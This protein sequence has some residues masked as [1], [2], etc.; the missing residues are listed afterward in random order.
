MQFGVQLHPESGADAVIREAQQA[1]ALGYDSVWLY[2]HLMNWAG[3]QTAEF[4]L[5]TLTLAAAIGASTRRVRLSWAVLNLGFYNPALLAK[6]LATIDQIT[7]G[8][9][10]C[11]AGSGWF[12]E[13]CEAYNVPMIEDHDERS[14]AAY[15]AVTLIKQ[16]WA[17]PAPATTT[18]DGK[19]FRTTNLPFQPA[20]YTPLGP[21]IWIGGESEATRRIV[22]DHASGWV[23]LQS[24]PMDLIQQVISAPDWP[25]RPMTVVKTYR[26]VV[27]ET[28]D[29]ALR[30]AQRTY[31][32]R[33]KAREAQIE[34]PGHPLAPMISFEEFVEREIVGSPDECFERIDALEAMGVN[35]IRLAYDDPQ[36][37]EAVAR[38]IL[39]HYAAAATRDGASRPLATAVA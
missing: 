13:E 34:Q 33:R 24:T 11:T 22:K 35:Y 8:R 26:V 9:V 38:L 29:D 4:P 25:R 16:L 7:H 37:L 39:P 27:G 23:L 28:R 12:K 3:I 32:V 21:P 14:A 2:D 15:E 30:A 36:Q 1:D 31:Q 18:F 20:P 17:H 19:Y 10:I 5:D 6:S